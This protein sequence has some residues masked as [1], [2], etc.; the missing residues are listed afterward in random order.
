MAF[1]R[2]AVRSR[3][4]PPSQG[5]VLFLASERK[6]GF[7]LCGDFYN[8]QSHA[9]LRKIN[10]EI[11]VELIVPVDLH[12]ADQAVDDLAFRD[13]FHVLK[14]LAYQLINDPV[15]NMCRVARLPV[16]IGLL[17]GFAVTDIPHP[18]DLLNRSNK[19]GQ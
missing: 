8:I 4:S 12:L 2:S 3:L 14:D 9:E 10:V 17:A 19:N 11:N 6:R 16:T 18:L 15:Q 5:K 7:V 13:R 1:K